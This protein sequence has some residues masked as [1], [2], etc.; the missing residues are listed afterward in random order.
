MKE[1]DSP[2]TSLDKALENMM[3]ES[4]YGEDGDDLTGHFYPSVSPSVSFS[5]DEE[6]KGIMQ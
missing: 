6:H 3:Q 2:K 4:G 5:S 1:L